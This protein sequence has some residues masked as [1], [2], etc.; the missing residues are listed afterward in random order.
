LSHDWIADINFFEQLC[1][2]DARVA[3][4][5]KSAGCRQCSGRL[6]RAD[7]P[8]KPRGGVVGA[9]GEQ[10]ERRLSFCCSRE[11]CRRRATPPS[12]LFLGR[13]VYLG[14]VVVVETL[15]LATASAAAPSPSPA[16]RTVRRWRTWFAALRRS[17]WCAA[18]SGRLWP[19]LEPSE[20]LPHALVD[21]L[22][23]TPRPV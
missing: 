10:I 4:A 16:R 20:S 5:V 23:G 6:D 15:R 9:A 1:A 19:P 7:Y 21:R 3:A 14:I 13:R 8:R 17:A 11:G 2:E 18:I 22:T 12:V